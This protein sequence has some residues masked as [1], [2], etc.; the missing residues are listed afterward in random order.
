MIR[1]LTASLALGALCSLGFAAPAMATDYEVDPAHSFIQFRIQ[2]LGYSWLI[3]RFNNLNGS[4]T[5]DASNPSQSNIQVVIDTRSIDTNHTKRDKHLRSEDFLET[6]TY[7]KAT[8]TST[9]FEGDANGGKLTGDLTLH[10]VTRPITL[11]VS[12]I[13][14]GDDPWS[15]Y[16]A[17]FEGT[18]LLTRS[19]YGMDYDLGPA[20]QSM[21][22]ELYIEGIRK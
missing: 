19:D 7:P 17:G 6:D 20:S 22:L 3:G 16:R 5:Y 8:F 18:T 9:A 10:G 11:E 4:F 21:E 2:H 15:G 1:S 12:K 13:S 14:E